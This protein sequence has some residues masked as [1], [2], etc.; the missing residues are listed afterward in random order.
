MSRVVDDV[1]VMMEVGRSLIDRPASSIASRLRPRGGRPGAPAD[2][3]TQCGSSGGGRRPGGAEGR[4]L[5]VDA[6][7]STGGRSADRRPDVRRRHERGCHA[8]ATRSRELFAE[9]STR[10]WSPLNLPAGLDKPHAASRRRRIRQYNAQP[11]LPLTT[12]RIRSSSSDDLETRNTGSTLPQM[13][14]MPRWRRWFRSRVGG[15]SSE[16]LKRCSPAVRMERRSAG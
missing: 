11:R 6:P 15:S 1:E 9:N 5:D 16:R 8:G 14:T 13:T 10:S 7:A 2:D 12:L 4:G 3:A